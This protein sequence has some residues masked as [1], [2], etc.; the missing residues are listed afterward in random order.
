[1]ISRALARVEF[2]FQVLFGTGALFRVGTSHSSIPLRITNAQKPSRRDAKTW[3]HMFAENNYEPVN[4]AFGKAYTK[5]QNYR[6][7]LLCIT[8]LR[9]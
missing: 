7:I 1:M 5:R 4:N 9:L 8:F 3:E 6:S 2:L